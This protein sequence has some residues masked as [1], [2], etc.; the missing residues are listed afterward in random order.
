MINDHMYNWFFI[1]THL[2]DSGMTN[3][4]NV[5]KTA[6]AEQTNIKILQFRIPAQDR[7]PTIKPP[8]YAEK[9]A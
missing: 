5:I 8:T 1:R 4:T 3:R 7:I 6:G 2:G 9:L